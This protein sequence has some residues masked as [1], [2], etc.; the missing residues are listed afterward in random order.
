MPPFWLHFP[1]PGASWGPLGAVLARLEGVLGRL[2]GILGASWRDFEKTLKK[3]TATRRQAPSKKSASLPL[4]ENR[5]PFP[6]PNLPPWNQPVGLTRNGS[7]QSA[8]R[9]PP[10]SRSRPIASPFPLRTTPLD[11]ACRPTENGSAQSASRHP[12][13]CGV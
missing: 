8:S 1:S 6:L 2:G 9:H 7:A 3:I 13:P 10:A 12:P 11:P 4:N 5:E